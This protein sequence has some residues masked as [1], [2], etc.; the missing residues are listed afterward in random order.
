MVMN[1]LDTVT[2]LGSLSPVTRQSILEQVIDQLNREFSGTTLRSP[3]MDERQAIQARA[4]AL[5]AAALTIS[6]PTSDEP[7]KATLAASG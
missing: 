3:E 6:R 7:V 5:V 2:T 1:M 4:G